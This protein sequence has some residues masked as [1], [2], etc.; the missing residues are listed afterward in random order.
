MFRQPFSQIQGK[1]KAGAR[2]NIYKA[3]DELYPTVVLFLLSE[4]S[5]PTSFSV[6]DSPG[7]GH[8]HLYCEVTTK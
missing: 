2:Y 7:P 4:R 8:I 5:S 1:G 3:G 6:N